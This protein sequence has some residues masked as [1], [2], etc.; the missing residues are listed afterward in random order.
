MARR[1]AEKREYKLISFKAFTDE[2]ADLLAWWESIDSGQRS[3]ALRDLLRMALGYQPFTR[4]STEAMAEDIAWMRD[5]LNELPGY[6]E[7]VIEHVVANAV[8]VQPES[9]SPPANG[10]SMSDDSARRREERMKRRQW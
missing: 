5:A 4:P 7:R 9:R 10:H 6:V 2:D 8:I 3:D 1:K